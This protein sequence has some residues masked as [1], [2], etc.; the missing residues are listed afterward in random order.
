MNDLLVRALGKFNF[1]PN[2]PRDRNGR[3]VHAGDSADSDARSER[4]GEAT[5]NTGAA[6]WPSKAP[7]VRNA[8]DA[9]SLIHDAAYQGDF[10]DV[11][12]GDWLAYL[13][14]IGRV[15][16]DEVRLTLSG[17]TARLDILCRLPVPGALIGF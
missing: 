11:V 13:N 10:H 15:C 4:P 1:D 7:A 16:V 6:D 12:K 8:I 5:S 17:V 9:A 2:Q 14:R 3:W